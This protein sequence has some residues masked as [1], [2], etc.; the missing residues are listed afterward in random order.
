MITTHRR[1][2]CPICNRCRAII[3]GLLRGSCWSNTLALILEL[4]KLHET[5]TKLFLSLFFLNWT[6]TD[7]VHSFTVDKVTGAWSASELAA[8]SLPVL[9]EVGLDVLESIQGW[10]FT[11][12]LFWWLSC[13]SW[14]VLRWH[15]TAQSALS[16][17]WRTCFALIGHSPILRS[18]SLS[19]APVRLVVGVMSWILIVIISSFFWA[20][21]LLLRCGTLACLVF[22]TH[23]VI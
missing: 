18:G 21:L 12:F 13:R 19:F 23:L 2:N 20:R 8:D 22:V 5:F 1:V 4:L 3:H 14:L 17:D 15:F 11:R 6:F 16:W 7:C 9:F 10:H